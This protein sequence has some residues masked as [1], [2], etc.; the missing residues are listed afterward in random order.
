MGPGY[1]TVITYI[2]FHKERKKDRKKEKIE[3]N[4]FIYNS[5][6]S[7]SNLTKLANANSKQLWAAV[8]SSVNSGSSS[9]SSGY[10]LLNDVN[11]VND[12]LPTY[13]FFL[14]VMVVPR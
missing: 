8:K 5:H 10:P 6:C 7:S 14:E 4:K 9:H 12:C 1:N 13:L 3:K 11:S 2:K